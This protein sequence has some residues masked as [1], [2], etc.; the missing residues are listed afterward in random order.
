L[1]N[2]SATGEH[3]LFDDT[4]PNTFTFDTFNVRPAGANKGAAQIDMNSFAV[5]TN[6]VTFATPLLG[7]V[8]GNGV[9]N[10]AD[11]QAMMNALSDLNDYTGNRAVLDVDQS[12]TVDNLDTQALINLIANTPPP[13]GVLSAV[14]EPPA[15]TLLCLGGIGLALAAKHGRRSGN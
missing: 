13:A 2:N 5:E 3:V 8:D 9:V 11:V 10:V 12:G 6:T 15:W 4:T 7:D 14:P 1:L